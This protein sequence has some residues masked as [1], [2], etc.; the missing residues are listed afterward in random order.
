MLKFYFNSVYTFW[1]FIIVCE[2]YL[3]I[4]F[5]VSFILHFNLF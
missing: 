5:T 2:I 4:I 3:H 1:I